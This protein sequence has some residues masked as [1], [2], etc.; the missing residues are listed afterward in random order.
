MRK[1]FTKDN[2]VKVLSFFY[3]LGMLTA[4]ATAVT[5][6]VSA[7]IA[8]VGVAA[9]SISASVKDKNLKKLSPIVNVLALNIDKAKN[10]NFR[11]L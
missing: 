10:D 4:G 11:N 8:G 6:P 3:K 9:A 1:I 2:A 7:I 5:N